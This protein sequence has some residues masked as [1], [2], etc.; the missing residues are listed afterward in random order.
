MF[1]H[2]GRVGMGSEFTVGVLMAETAGSLS[3][4]AVSF[5]QT[6][7]F[8]NVTDVAAAFDSGE[9]AGPSS[10]GAGP[11]TAGGCLAYRAGSTTRGAGFG[12]L[13]GCA[14]PYYAVA[15]VLPCHSAA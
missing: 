9:V 2:I 3:A 8:A 1:T 10:G 14:R 5:T 7:G 12:T 15:V 6:W 13:K 11:F 4:A